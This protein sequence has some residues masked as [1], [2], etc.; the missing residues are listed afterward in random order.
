MSTR[1]RRRALVSLLLAT[2]VSASVGPVLAFTNP[3]VRKEINRAKASAGRNNADGQAAAL[4]RLAW[5]DEASSDPELRAAARYELVAYGHDALS[6]LRGAIKRVDPIFSADVTLTLIEARYL[7]AAGSP[8]DYLPGLEDAIW[9]GSVEAQRIAILEISRHHFPPAVL[10]TIDAMRSHPELLP[11]G[12]YALGR[13]RDSR[14]R[15]YLSSVVKEG[16]DRHRYAA[17]IALAAVGDSGVKLLREV[18]ASEE[19]QVRRAA[20]RALIPGA[21]RGDLTLLH[22]F[23]RDPTVEDP[24]L[25]ELALQKAV[26]LERRLDLELAGEDEP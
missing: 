21:E 10:S 4:T 16:P 8:R 19:P 20:I 23:A 9:N 6:A 18:A 25:A 14:A 2:V 22:A 7:E 5:P 15:F 24:E 1:T 26:E 12:I 17:A 3:R 11:T 13:M